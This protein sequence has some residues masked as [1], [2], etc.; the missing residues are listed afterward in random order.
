MKTYRSSHHFFLATGLNAGFRDFKL[1]ESNS[2][3]FLFGFLLFPAGNGISWS[4]YV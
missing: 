3:L 2:N 1:M 4:T